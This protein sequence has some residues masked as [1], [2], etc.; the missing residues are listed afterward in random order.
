[1]KVSLLINDV[2]HMS[3]TASRLSSLPWTQSK[4][5]VYKMICLLSYEKTPYACNKWML[6]SSDFI[7]F[8]NA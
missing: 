4:D 3:V 6:T 2:N 8:L 5:K 7:C 1:M